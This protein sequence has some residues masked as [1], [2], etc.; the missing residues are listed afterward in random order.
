MK[1]IIDYVIQDGKNIVSF[2]FLYFIIEDIINK[3]LT[4]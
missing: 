4:V 1:Y 3:T 2:V